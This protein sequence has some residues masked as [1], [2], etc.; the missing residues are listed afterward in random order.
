M[1]PN[2]IFLGLTLY[3]ICLCLAI[4]ACFVTVSA[5]FD[6]CNMNVKVQKFSVLCGVGA[7]ILGYFFAVLFQALYNIESIGRFEISMNTGATFYGGLIGG[8]AVFLA[9]YFGIGGFVFK[10]REHVK[11]FWTLANCA[12][13]SIALAHSIGR[14]GCLM[15]GCCHGAETDAWYGIMMYGDF[16]Y[17][18]YVPVQLFES[19]FLAALFA[20]MLLRTLSKKGYG[21]S[22]YLIGYSVWRFF[23]EYLRADYRGTTFIDWLTPSQFIAVCLAIVGIALIFPERYA[24][25]TAGKHDSDT[26]V[27]IGGGT[28]DVE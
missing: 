28:D 15:A 9:L 27:G 6:K 19:V 5:L 11:S 12:A 18:K 16:G 2:E 22:V 17:G 25:K 4:V 3:D 21:L 1:Y 10:S 8:A 20:F 14:V 23:A 26:N 24:R 13:P 7:V